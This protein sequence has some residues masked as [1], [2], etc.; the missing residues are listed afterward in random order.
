[1]S[2]FQPY[3]LP[4]SSLPTEYDLDQPWN[5]QPC[6]SEARWRLFLAYRDQPPPRTLRGASEALGGYDERGLR[7]HASEDAWPERCAE[8]DRYLDEQRV[9]LIVDVLAEDARTTAARHAAI[10]RDAV[11][12]AHSVALEWLAKLAKGET[13]EGWSPNDVRG[14]IRDMVT[15]ERLVR[16]EATERV[17]HGIGFDLSRL[18]IGEIE[19]MRT[20]EAKA[21]VVE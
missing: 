2:L 14:M 5:R 16:G 7:R 11:E 19:T 6:D 17:E 15:L 3:H 13:L 4:V 10:A 12:A 18:T 21:G 20:L 1:M 8:F 9:A